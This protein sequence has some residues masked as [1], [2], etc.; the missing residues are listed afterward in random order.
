MKKYFLI[1]H[2]PG[3]AWIQGKGFQHQRLMDHGAYIHSLY[4]KGILIEGGP[5]LDNS[6]GMAIITAADAA[7]AEEIMNTD[8]A[9]QSGVFTAELTPWMR[10]DWGNYG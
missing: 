9:V 4:E 6:G 10:V 2:R 3:P 7:E 8:P 1:R 5:F